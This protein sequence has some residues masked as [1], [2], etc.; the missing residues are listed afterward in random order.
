MT[1][2]WSV[3]FV[4]LNVCRLKVDKISDQVLKSTILATGKYLLERKNTE[5]KCC[6]FLL[7]KCGMKVLVDVRVDKS[8]MTHESVTKDK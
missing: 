1:R 5:K 2:L 7:K 4:G 6:R 3:I 8:N